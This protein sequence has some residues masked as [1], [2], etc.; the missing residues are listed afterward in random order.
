MRC[1]ARVL[2]LAVTGVCLL[3]LVGCGG[4]Q[5]VSGEA[6]YVNPFIGTT[7]GGETFPGAD[8]PFGMVQWSPDTGNGRSPGGY[9]Y[10]NTNLKGFSL[11]HLSGAGCS[12]YGD[13]PFLP[14]TGSLPS[15]PGAASVSFS[16]SAEHASPGYYSVTLAN[17]AQA[18]LTVTQRSGIGVFTFPSGTQGGM[19]IKASGSANGVRASSVQIL[20]STEME[21]QATSG[22]FCGASDTYTVY[23]FAEF[24]HPFQSYGVWNGVSPDSGGTQ[25][26]GTDVGAYV[27]FAPGTQT[28]DMKVGLSFVSAADAKLN[29]QTEDPGWSFSGVQAQ[30]TKA[31]NALLDKIQITGGTAAQRTTFYTALYHAL[32]QPNVFS[33]VNGEYPAFEGTRIETAPRGTAQ[34][35]NIS[36]WDIYRS[37]TQLLA[38]LAPRQTSDMMQ[39]LVNDAAQG[40]WL[41]KW[42]VAN[43]YSSVMNG[44]SADAIIADAYAFGARGFDT[45]TA[46][47]YMIK[48]AT[49]TATS[50]YVERPGLQSYLQYG[51][52]PGQAANTL[53]YNVDDFAV[54]QFAQALGQSAISQRYMQR[55][56]GWTH[57]VDL[58]T[59]FLEPALAN[60]GFPASFDPT[61]G[62]GYR[63]GDA[64]QYT[65]AVP[66]NVR[67]L[68]SALGGASRVSS[69]LDSFFVQL[70]A[71]TAN[72]YYYAGNEPDIEVPWEYDFIGQPRQTES[73]VRRVQDQLFTDTTG[74]LPGNDDLGEMSSWYVWSALGM[75]PEIPGVAG[76]VLSSPL[77]P[78]ITVHLPS[79]GTFRITAP[80][81]SATAG[82]ILGASLNGKADN[83]T[84]LP[85]SDV[86]KGGTLAFRLSPAPAAS[87]AVSP[88][89]FL[90]SA[91]SPFG[92]APASTWGTTASDA[93]PSF[94][95][96][97][98]AAIAAVA[99][100]SAI[101]SPGQ[102]ATLHLTVRDLSSSAITAPWSI[103]A[104]SGLTAS[105]ASGTADLRAG[106][107]TSVSITVASTAAS[108]AGSFVIPIALHLPSGGTLDAASTISVNRPGT[109]SALFNNIAI[110]ADSAPAVADA[111]GVGNSYSAEA[112]AQDGLTPGQPFTFGGVTFQW[113]NA[114]PGAP[115]N[116]VAQ[117]QTITLAA[118]PGATALAFL[119]SATNGPASGSATI[120]YTDGSAQTF[121]LGFSDWTLGAGNASPSY[122]NVVAARTPY[123]NTSSGSSDPHATYVFYAQVPL[124]NGKTAQ[125][126]TL[127][128]TTSPTEIHIFAVAE[129]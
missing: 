24:S 110:S 20:D 59:G 81:A 90:L 98:P 85:L 129:K 25:A 72:R 26:A 82:Y 74:G 106:G 96:G 23:F 99:P 83:S 52:V 2:G 104:P 120:H 60:G 31:W 127:P 30:A 128:S 113:P 42:P 5:K 117:G 91:S 102:S 1:R 64:Y 65:W 16:H 92:T 54:A 95:T 43:G 47:Q 118:Q 116:I 63:E 12:T 45:K 103:A 46:L 119:G 122:G 10:A 39:S 55:A 35:A 121:T 50:G 105:P 109:I 53:E 29:L 124:A 75:Y 71:G 80:G 73:V 28:V 6:Q 41:P 33:D 27:D 32:L 8:V 112:L 100:P 107:S 9:D 58:G 67:G 49:Q 78:E 38:L 93:P 87:S 76:M 88:S 89:L 11:T 21:G 4:T 94:G 34:Y 7:N 48:G 15:D 97:M 19:L 57:L 111:D 51:F 44:D 3:A 13:F 126:I 70:N 86:Q 84:W 114:S 37:E 22:Q 125:S 62:A 68:T 18:Q 40:G 36:G 101:L 14:F 56:Q 77:F 61:S 123:R 66:F 108:P 79:G 17:G 69:A 115:D